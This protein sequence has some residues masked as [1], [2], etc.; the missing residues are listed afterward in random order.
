MVP[1]SM[2]ILI[3][4]AYTGYIIPIKDMV[5]WLDW[6]R[7]LNPIAFAYESLMI[8]EVCSKASTSRSF[9]K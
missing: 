1:S 2:V 8:N 6:L 7:R 5:P 3:F 9:A 4:S